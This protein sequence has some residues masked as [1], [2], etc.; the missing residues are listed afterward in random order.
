MVNYC[1][2]INSWINIADYKYFQDTF[3]TRKQSFTIGFSICITVP[4]TPSICLRN[5]YCNLSTKFLIFF[6][7]GKSHDQKFSTETEAPHTSES[8]RNYNFIKG[9]CNYLI[10]YVMN[11]YWRK[12]IR[13][14][15]GIFMEFFNIYFKVSIEGV[16]S[17]CV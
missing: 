11:I 5:L 14:P 13:R 10:H 1:K 15:T 4:L 3:E 2:I 17:R 16:D 9:L 8:N 6:S 12:I 7:E